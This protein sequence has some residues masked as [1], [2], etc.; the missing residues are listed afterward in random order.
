MEAKVDQRCPSCG[1]DIHCQASV[2]SLCGTGLLREVTTHWDC[3]ECGTMYEQTTPFDVDLFERSGFH[4]WVG[5]IRDNPACIVIDGA[6]VVEDEGE[7]VREDEG[8]RAGG[9]K[10]AGRRSGAD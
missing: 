1:T 3:P 10:R 2:E 8:I 4:S 5:S 9:R 6:D 7:Q